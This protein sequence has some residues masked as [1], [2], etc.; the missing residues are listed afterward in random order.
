MCFFGSCAAHPDSNAIWRHLFFVVVVVVV[1]AAA[2]ADAVVVAA[3]AH[4]HVPA[5]AAVHVRG[6]RLQHDDL[7]R[8]RRKVRADPPHRQDHRRRRPFTRQPSFT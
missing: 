1:V 4:H 2:V 6:A 7:L 5:G 8:A 3:G